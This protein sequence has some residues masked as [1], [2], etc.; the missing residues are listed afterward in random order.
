MECTVHTQKQI[1]SKIVLAVFFVTLL[2][3]LLFSAGIPNGNF[4][5]GKISNGIFT[6]D[7]WNAPGKNG[8][9]IEP[10]YESSKAIA[11]SG[12]GEDNA[13]WTTAAIALEPG[14]LYEFS[15]WAKADA[16]NQGGCAVS[17]PEYANRDYQFSEAWKEYSF[18]FRVPENRKQTMFRLGQWQIKGT[19]YFDA[20]TLTAVQPLYSSF[21]S[22]KLGS[23]EQIEQN[24]Y[25]AEHKMDSVNSN[26]CRFIKTCLAGFNSIR[27]LFDNNSNVTYCHELPGLPILDA[28]VEI[29]LN[30]YTNGKLQVFAQKTGSEWI[31][32]GE[33]NKVATQTFPLP[34]NLFP[35]QAVDI[36]LTGINDSSGKCNLQVDKY[37]FTANVEKTTE[38]M[39]GETRYIRISKQDPR[40]AVSLL[41]IGNPMPGV[42][43]ACALH[44]TNQDE[45]SIAAQI[46]L[47]IS[48]PA[49]EIT[50]SLALNLLGKE[51]K[52][53]NVDYAVLHTGD[54]MIK[55]QIVDNKNNELYASEVPFAVSFLH[56]AGFGEL[57]SKTDNRELWWCKGT[58]KVSQTRP[59]P[60]QK[61]EGI[62][63]SAAKGEF[64][65]FQLVI[66]PKSPITN[67]KIVPVDMEG[68]SGARIDKSNI[69][70]KQVEYVKVTSPSD[71]WGVQDLWPDPLPD[72]NEPVTLE[73][74]RNWPL[75]ISVKIPV[76]AT[77]GLYRGSLQ[78]SSDGWND[79][80]PFLVQVYDFSLP[81][82]PSLKTAFGFSVAEV[83]RFHHLQTLDEVEKVIDL[84]YQNFRD[85]R[86]TPDNATSLHPIKYELLK[87]KLEFRFDFSDFER[88]A[89]HY[90]DDYGFSTF[91]LPM[92]GL[93]GGTFESRS[94]GKIGSF[95]QGTPEH[96][97]LFK[98]YAS[99][100]E[101]YLREK[102]WLDKGYIYWFDEPE[103]KDYAF[104]CETMDLIHRNAPGLKRMLTEQPEKELI[105]YVDIW[106]SI[107]DQYNPKTC[108]ARQQAGEEIWWYIC[109][110]PKQ[111]YPGLFIDHPA[112][113]LRAWL[114]M[115]W[116]YQVQGCLVW[117]SNYW[118]SDTAFPAP[119]IQ[120]PWQDPMSY[121]TGYSKPDGFIGL[122][123]NG[124]GRFM[125]PPKDWQ[126]NS[127]K[128]CGPVDSIRWEML[129][130]GME[131]Y[132]Y[133][134]LLKN[135]VSSGTLS[136]SQKQQAEKLLQIPDSVITSRTAYNKNPESMVAIRDAIAQ[137]IEQNQKGQTAVKSVKQ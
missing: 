61:G 103:E 66:H 4:E 86:I 125:Y 38:S 29:N 67:F 10:G 31:L 60:D 40:L 46:N 98:N 115:T 5:Q 90:F 55:L 105:G 53:L 96:E 129:R 94:K 119:A 99:T 58:Y 73:S 106:C 87:D 62:K 65:P 113:D 124:D 45:T 69:S 118:T 116:K 75:W 76:D 50:K 83:K 74:A 16:G 34:E 54:Q 52:N 130:E 43:T 7:N 27:W 30:Y 51:E 135:I 78:I 49:G 63:I 22:I 89:K 82:S 72:L 14:K 3:G 26:A 137:F 107:L 47:R 56:D 20:V 8:S 57:I 6:P 110:G 126:S 2:P 114:W 32:L 93:G 15:F 36:K 91:R 21:G 35:A 59:A 132:E 39:S 128:I 101:N 97:K 134:H 48:H 117:Q 108:P 88:A 127:K 24:R 1:T 85:H 44:I 122:W 79:S 23:G 133:F 19:V 95:E 131:D 121:V 120:N 81:K 28:S 64:E 37:L 41:S 42:P 9:V 100:L 13:S 102:G 70:V 71:M 77:A 109:T 84:Y 25:I 33:M 80:I 68:P 11:V 17:G 92:I 112:V 104:V 18:V 12:D 111:P 136:D 123:G